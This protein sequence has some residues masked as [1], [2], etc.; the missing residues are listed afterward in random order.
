MFQSDPIERRFG[1][2]RRLS[3]DIYYIS[4]R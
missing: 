1:W 3:G 4:V 2:Y